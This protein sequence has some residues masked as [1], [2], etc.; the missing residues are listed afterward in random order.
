MY[1]ALV[2]VLIGFTPGLFVGLA[3]GVIITLIFIP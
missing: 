2:L 1:D 3:C